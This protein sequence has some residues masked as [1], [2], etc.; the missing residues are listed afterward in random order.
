MV[1]SRSWL[2]RWF[3]RHL[4]LLKLQGFEPEQLAELSSARWQRLRVEPQFSLDMLLLKCLLDTEG[5]VLKREL[6]TWV[7][8]SGKRYELEI[9][10]GILSI[11]K[12]FSGR[13]LDEIRTWVWIE[14]GVKEQCWDS[15][16]DGWIRTSKR[17]LQ[18]P[19][20]GRRKTQPVY[21][22]GSQVRKCIE[23]EGKTS[24]D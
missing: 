7:W 9:H 11:Q 21:H 15:N 14:R 3:H 24:Y 13:K 12:V 16:T 10:L 19:P 6:D 22:P 2:W 17:R 23:A 4:Q 1:F 8:S 20:W 5:A 18:R